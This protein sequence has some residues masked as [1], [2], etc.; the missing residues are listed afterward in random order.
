MNK[1][2]KNDNEDTTKAYLDQFH[3]DNERNRRDIGLD[4][5]DESSDLVKNNQDNDFKDNK[6]ANIDSIKN[7]RTPNSDDE[8]SN[9]KK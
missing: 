4:F 1:Q 3:N 2:A 8:V 6:P 5:C 7:N 9:K